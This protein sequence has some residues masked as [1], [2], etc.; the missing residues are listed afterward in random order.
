MGTAT[1]VADPPGPA[2]IELEPV[3]TEPSVSLGVEVT[4]IAANHGGTGPFTYLCRRT[5]TL[6]H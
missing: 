6:G 2:Q 5:A 3:M 1:L 4:L